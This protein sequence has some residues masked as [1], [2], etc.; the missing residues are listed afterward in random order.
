ATEL[1]KKLT[2]DHIPDHNFASVASGRQ[3]PA[4]GGKCNWPA[5]AIE[6]PQRLTGCN[7]PQTHLLVPGAGRKHPPVRPRERN[8]FDNAFVLQILEQLPRPQVDQSCN[9]LPAPDD[10]QPLVRGDRYRRYR[11]TRNSIQLRVY[12]IDEAS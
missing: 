2:C 10:K 5:V 6:R 9:V 12:S 11:V 3:V 4:I 8:R 7:I 1:A